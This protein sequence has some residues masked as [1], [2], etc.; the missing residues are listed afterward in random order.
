MADIANDPGR[1]RTGATSWT[2]RIRSYLGVPLHK[3]GRLV[4]AVGLLQLTPRDWRPHEI[5]LLQQVANRCWES[6]ERARA[7]AHFREQWETIDTALANTP[8]FTYTFDLDGRFTYINRA[9]LSL[10]RKSLDEAVGKNFFELDYPPDLAARLQRQIQQVIDTKAPVKD[11][12][13]YTD[14]LGDAGYYEYIF[15]PV[16]GAG[17]RV[18]GVAGST[19]DITERERMSR[20]LAASQQKLQQVFAQA[21]VAIAVFRGPEFVVEL[22]NPSYEALLG[23][24]ELIGRSLADIVPELSEN[25]WQAFH[26]VMATGEPFVANE[27]PVLYDQNCDGQAEDHW[28]NLVYHPLREG[29]GSVSGIVAVCSEVTAQV[30]SRQDL[31]R[32]NRELEEFAYVASHDLQEPLRMVGIYTELLLGRFLPENPVALEFGGFV[33]EGVQ[34]MQK[35]IQDLLT[36]SRVI[37][38]DGASSEGAD[39]NESLGQALRILGSRLKEAGARVTAAPLPVVAGDTDQL[40]H[41]FQNLLSN[42]LKYRDTG[43]TP[44][45]RISAA[46]CGGQWTV[47]VEDNGIGF[48]QQYAERIFGLFK[49]LHKDEYSGTGLGL[50]ICQRILERYGGRI[51]ADGR[52]GEGATFYFTLPDVGAQ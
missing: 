32:V 9:L 47:C 27:F 26:R 50:A 45:I 24:R 14:P 36:Y 39:L 11:H 41:V 22:A 10:W 35:L 21:P 1:E 33:R 15:V 34:R 4:A 48:Q 46:P 51:W 25:V 43:R 17:G 16:F 2:G 23:G 38:N 5:E 30:R 29:D 7:Q 28:F 44:E 49:R 19:R 18:C 37:H 3:H 31:E 8:D 6:I 40:M 20:A 13:P 42:S 12:T 52:P